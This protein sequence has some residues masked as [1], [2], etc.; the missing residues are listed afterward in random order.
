[1]SPKGSTSL[2][3]G[4]GGGGKGRPWGYFGGNEGEKGLS[5]AY[6]RRN[7]EVTASSARKNETLSS[8]GT[9]KRRSFAIRVSST[10]TTAARTTSLTS[11]LATATATVV[12]VRTTDTPHGM[13][14]LP[15]NAK[16]MK[17]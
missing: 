12:G 6:F 9:R 11:R 3:P 10:A 15:S 1:M 4:R 17:S 2:E 5:M 8:S 7:D 16:K 13:K 14:R